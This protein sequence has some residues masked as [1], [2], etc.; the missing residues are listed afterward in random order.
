MRK[1]KVLVWETLATVSG[2]QKMTLTI[3]DM[4][5]DKFEFCCLIP[6]KGMMSEELKKRNI[7]YVLMGDQTLPTGVKGKQVIFK[8]GLMSVKSVWKSLGVIRKYRP[9][10]LYAPGPAALPW[11]AVCGTL[12]RKPVIWHLHH[13]FLDGTT[14]KLLNVCG[15]WKSIWEIIAV[16]NCVGDQ[17]ANEKAHEKVNVL[18][19]PVNVEKYANGNA[20]RITME[21][22]SKLG[23]KITPDVADSKTIVIGH[24]ALIQRSKKQWFTLKLIEALRKNG[25]NA[26]GVFAGECR[27]PEYMIELNQKVEQYGLREHVIF[28]GRRND[29]PDLLKMIDMLII[30]S[31]EGFP[32]AGL[33]AAAAGVPVIACDAAG[34]EE[35]I[36][37]SGDGVSFTEDDVARAVD[38][39]GKILKEKEKY[40]KAG[41][42]F[43]GQMSN[44]EYAAKIQQ[45]FKAIEQ[46]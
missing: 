18:Y 16:S 42:E 33:E 27:E 2:G 45:V 21:V 30:P 34:A 39:V 6:A 41:I 4:L 46:S 10:I 43:A 31:F 12:T 22:E 15:R 14:K 3:M 32:L 17:I 37:V 23:R 13:I 35:F 25:Y 38:A 36:H 7:P 24:V 9:D 26:V 29:I 5:A 11:S 20:T 1:R 44:R 40:K 28:L 19:N 8:Y